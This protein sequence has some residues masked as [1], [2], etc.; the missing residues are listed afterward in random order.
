MSLRFSNE[1][2]ADWV[3]QTYAGNPSRRKTDIKYRLVFML[4]TAQI[5]PYDSLD[6]ISLSMRK[7]Y[8]VS[9][10]GRRALSATPEPMEK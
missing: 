4:S 1:I 6:H 2:C 7:M 3:L 9:A 8:F 5:L 10:L